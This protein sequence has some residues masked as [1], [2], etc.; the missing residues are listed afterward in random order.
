MATALDVVQKGR[1]LEPM[2]N[3]AQKQTPA[4]Q[5]LGGATVSVRETLE[6]IDAQLVPQP[7]QPFRII[8]TGFGHLD[9]AVGGGLRVGELTLIAGPPGVG[10]TTFA[11]QM[12]RN[13]VDEDYAAFF[14]CF[15]HPETDLLVRL[16]AM[17]GALSATNGRPGPTIGEIRRLFAVAPRR[18][19]S[20]LKALAEANPR[21]ADAVAAVERIGDRLV[22]QRKSGRGLTVPTIELLVGA[23]REEARR[24]VV[25]FIDYLQKI[26]NRPGSVPAGDPTTRVVESLKELA[27]EQGVAIVAVS[28]LDLTGIQARRIN[29]HHL[30]GGPSLAYEADVI[31][32]LA[33]KADC[34]SRVNYAYSPYRLEAFREWVVASLVKNRSGRDLVDL[35]FRKR[36]A[37]GCF[38]P[39]G[40]AVAE[41]LIDDQRYVE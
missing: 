12:A 14:L 37:W 26:P 21:L 40:G 1:Q 2:S 27:L 20:S 30:L 5:F 31:L 7:I 28:A 18:P 13:V 11:L 24:P 16:I 9:E 10:K 29:A 33:E 3:G 34:V 41:K 35:E 6:R 17:E 19:G 15:E 4:A 8:P 38:D 23:L 36:F 25:V 22:L 39:T 32:A